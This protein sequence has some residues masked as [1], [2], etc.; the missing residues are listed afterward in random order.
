VDKAYEF[1]GRR[2]GFMANAIFAFS[3]ASILRLVF[4]VIIRSVY[5]TKQPFFNLT[6]GPENRVHFKPGSRWNRWPDRGR[7]PQPATPHQ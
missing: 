1:L 6:G 2:S 7:Y 4:F 3:V 5:Q